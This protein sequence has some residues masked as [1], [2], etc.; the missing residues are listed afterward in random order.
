MTTTT[1]GASA[2]TSTDAGVHSVVASLDNGR[3]GVRT[4]R[5]E[6]GRL[7]KLA[8]GA[9]VAYLGDLGLE[10]AEGQ[11]GLLPPHRRRR[12]ADVCG[13]AHPR[14]VLPPRGPPE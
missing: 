10:E 2:V 9:A 12:G 5:F 8:N 13:R 3:F 6:T 14:F 1:T 7:A 11:P 4:I